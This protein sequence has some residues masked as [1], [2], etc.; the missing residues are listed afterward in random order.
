MSDLVAYL[1]SRG[2]VSFLAMDA[3]VQRWRREGGR[4]ATSILETTDITPDG[5]LEALAAYSR[6]LPA[7][8]AILAQVDP[9]LAEMFNADRSLRL[10]AFPLALDHRGLVLGVLNR[11]S[12]S[13]L[14]ELAEEFSSSIE[15]RII[16][17]FR[18]FELLNRFYG[19][20]IE[21]R[22]LMLASRFPLSEKSV[23]EFEDDFFT[24]PPSAEPPSRPSL[25]DLHTPAKPL[26]PIDALV[27]DLNAD[28]SPLIID[29]EELGLLQSA[30]KKVAR[31]HESRLRALKGK[32]SSDPEESAL[33]QDDSFEAAFNVGADIAADRRANQ[34]R[35]IRTAEQANLSFAPITSPAETTKAEEPDHLPLIQPV[36]RANEPPSPRM[37]SMGMEP[38][39]PPSF[40]T[41]R[42]RAMDPLSS[43]WDAEDRAPN[44]SSIEAVHAPDVKNKRDTT[45]EHAI[46]NVSVPDVMPPVPYNVANASD[47]SVARHLGFWSRDT[48]DHIDP[49]SFTSST[50]GQDWSASQL[51]AFFAGHRT[52]D[53]LLNATFGYTKHFY[54]RRF[55]L[56]VSNDNKTYVVAMQGAQPTD[57]DITKVAIPYSDDSTIA[58]IRAEMTYFAGPP[59]D[60]GLSTL[61]TRLHIERPQEMVVFPIRISDRAVMLLAADSGPNAFID[62][63]RLDDV[64]H[65]LSQLGLAL[66]RLITSNLRAQR[67]AEERT[68]TGVN[69]TLRGALRDVTSPL[70]PVEAVPAEK[71]PSIVTETKRPNTSTAPVENT[72]PKGEITAETSAVEPTTSQ[73]DSVSPLTAEN[74][75]V[76]PLTSENSP[77]D[78]LTSENSVV[79]DQ[80][81]EQESVQVPT[82]ETELVEAPEINGDIEENTKAPA[83]ITTPSA[84]FP[85]ED[86]GSS[87]A[88]TKSDSDVDEDYIRSLLDFDNDKATVAVPAALAQALATVSVSPQKEEDASSAT[89]PGSRGRFAHR[90]KSSWGANAISSLLDIQKDSNPADL[91]A[92]QVDGGLG[93]KSSASNN[94]AAV[95]SPLEKDVAVEPAKPSTAPADPFSNLFEDALI[96]PEPVKPAEPAALSKEERDWASSPEASD[97]ELGKFALDSFTSEDN[98]TDV[99]AL[100]TETTIDAGSDV[101]E[102]SVTPEHSESLE[103]RPAESTEEASEE[104]ASQ[105][106]VSTEVSAEEIALPLESSIEPPNASAIEETPETIESASTNND[107]TDVASAEETDSASQESAAI[108]KDEASETPVK[109]SIFDSPDLDELFG[110]VEDIEKSFADI[111]AA[112]SPKAETPQPVVHAK[113]VMQPDSKSDDTSRNATEDI[114]PLVDLIGLDDDW[115]PSESRIA[116]IMPPPAPPVA[117]DTRQNAITAKLPSSSPRDG[118][119]AE[120]SEAMKEAPSHQSET[121]FTSRHSTLSAASTKPAK[122]TPPPPAPVEPQAPAA[123]TERLFTP[124]LNEETNESK[125][126]ETTTSPT[127]RPV[128]PTRTSP[129]IPRGLPPRPAGLKDR[130]PPPPVVP[131]IIRK[132]QDEEPVTETAHFFMDEEATKP[133]ATNASSQSEEIRLD[134]LFGESSNA[135]EEKGPTEISTLVQL[136]DIPEEQRRAAT[137]AISTVGNAITETVFGQ[138]E[139][140]DAEFERLL[141]APASELPSIVAGFPGKLVLNRHLPEQDAR[142]VREHSRLLA[143]ID[144]RLDHWLP[145]VWSCLERSSD[146]ARYYALRLIALV[147]NPE[148]RYSLIEALFDQDRQV[149][150]LALAIVETHRA[151]VDFQTVLDAVRSNLSSEN[152]RKREAA[153]I[154]AERLRDVDSIPRLIELLADESSDVQARARESLNRLTFN[155]FGQSQT[156]WRQWYSMH[157]R[158]LPVEWLVEAMTALEPL[159]RE[160]AARALA[161]MPNLAVNYHPDMSE[162]AL[163]RARLAAERH[164]GIR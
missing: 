82:T 51:S 62:R 85:S 96:P 163:R 131:P 116:Q 122:S 140:S 75:P 8:D 86:A 132:E 94:F 77:V 160:L 42:S 104:A 149:Q 159:R 135:S 16:L 10:G 108:A 43:F 141:H 120:P 74:L 7:N 97:E 33:F 34:I 11:L 114:D 80:T 142:P 25:Q 69:P 129:A 18:F 65:V 13:A 47:D 83:K 61:Y 117:N 155:D 89:S 90:G 127:S 151:H 12:T 28:N 109:D 2:S 37:K 63:S 84:T 103:Q 148:L 137:I 152:E 98:A 124:S 115:S 17:E 147:R 164:F 67:I 100:S 99:T 150:R 1:V 101:S 22:Y 41:R 73:N 105:E 70:E 123:V 162:K 4:L 38:I 134:N 19:H 146:A 139:I 20:P 133:S 107:A 144:A 23:E 66:Q 72:I 102:L 6:L 93:R 91:A 143:L 71:Q 35:S 130:L 126:A 78:P 161:Q 29:P 48:A 46:Q 21:G 87:T 15:Q 118:L 36:L 14:D 145:E 76:E 154:A 24:T 59:Q 52:R 30:Q 44:Q 55:F 39:M 112:V 125:D 88:E 110:S 50:L 157:G 27:A 3:A 26:S 68:P 57:I 156:E 81:S 45:A 58:Q 9:D 128:S 79:S 121:P 106:S 138:A 5:I 158:E 56:R 92:P 49:N 153:A 40:D 64:F 32:P 136:S 119:S 60:V 54:K 95:P 111:F 113:S 31:I 53:E